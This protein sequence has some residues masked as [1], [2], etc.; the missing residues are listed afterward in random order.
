M[1]SAASPKTLFNIVRDIPSTGDANLYPFVFQRVSQPIGI[2]S[3]IPQEPIS[4]RQATQ[5][6]RCAGVVA[7]L[8]GRHE[9]PDR[10]A[11]RIGDGM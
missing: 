6:R 9:E 10:A 2:V 5:Q 8:S 7:H 11:R 3:T 4:L 1:K